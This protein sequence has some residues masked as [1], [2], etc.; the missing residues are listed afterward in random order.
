M[1]GRC[2]VVWLP[3][4]VRC[5]HVDGGLLLAW[6]PRL[7]ENACWGSGGEHPRSS[8]AAARGGRWSAQSDRYARSRLAIA[9]GRHLV[10]SFPE[11]VPASSRM[12]SRSPDRARGPPV[13][14]DRDLM[15][16]RIW[17]LQQLLTT[18]ISVVGD[19]RDR[20]AAAPTQPATG[21]PDRAQLGA[22][23]RSV[24]WQAPEPDRDRQRS[25]RR[26]RRPATGSAARLDSG[27][28][29]GS[30][31][32]RCHG[33]AP[34]DACPPSCTRVCPPR[35]D[36]RRAVVSTPGPSPPLPSSALGQA[37]R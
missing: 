4:E 11:T 21:V 9:L 33:E 7:C 3:L 2:R 24:D 13:T 20:R 28:Q 16:E 10:V 19:L 12:R 23:G 6:S 31:L 22:S 14:S 37:Q 34:V 27:G 35:T 1:I 5:A 18:G 30:E 26:P 15:A 25:F 36:R 32:P 17:L 8:Q 29:S